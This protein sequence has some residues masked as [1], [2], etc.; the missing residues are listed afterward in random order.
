MTRAMSNFARENMLS[1]SSDEA[2]LV[3]VTIRHAATGTL[4]RA[5]N[6]TEQIISRGDTFEPYPFSFILPQETG[7]GIGVAT[8]EIDN[9][10]LVLIDMLRSAVT[11]PRVDIEII[12]GSLPD[13][14]EIGIYDLALR[15]VSWDASV[16]RGKLLNE[17]LLSTG[18]PSYSYVP[19]EWQ[20]I[21]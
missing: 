14:V 17:D 10:D 6:N 9:V 13:V 3:L 8:F 20:G 5:V 16:I 21:F 19:T 15:E 1:T 12:L 18:F 4:L 11:A 7:E 2:F